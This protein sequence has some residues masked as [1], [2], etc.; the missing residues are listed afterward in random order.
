M[1]LPERATRLGAPNQRH[2][3]ATVRHA[4]VRHDRLIEDI[5]A[6]GA[7][8]VPRWPANKNGGAGG[9]GRAL[10]LAA[11]LVGRVARRLGASRGGRFGRLSGRLVGCASPLARPVAAQEVLGGLVVRVQQ[12][13]EALLA[14]KTKDARVRDG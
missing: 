8:V 4:I 3:R 6:D 1:G 7:Q 11:R 9:V 5:G 10:G 12:L 2:A 13:Q 14:S